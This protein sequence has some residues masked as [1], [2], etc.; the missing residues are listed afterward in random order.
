[1]LYCCRGFASNAIALTSCAKPF[2]DCAQSQSVAAHMVSS[3]AGAQL[4]ATVVNFSSNHT[5]RTQLR[6]LIL[7]SSFLQNNGLKV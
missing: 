5:R 7:L 2:G 1:M 3:S 4:H 6:F